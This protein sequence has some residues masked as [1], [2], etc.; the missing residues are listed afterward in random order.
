[1]IVVKQENETRCPSRRSVE[2][3]SE[4]SEGSSHLSDR[5]EVTRVGGA[6]NSK[7]ARAELRAV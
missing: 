4:R 5:I 7:I 6:P 3:K 1:M 2:F